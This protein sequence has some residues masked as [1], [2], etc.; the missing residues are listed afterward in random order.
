MFADQGEE[1]YRR[2]VLEKKGGWWQTGRKAK[3][4]AARRIKKIYNVTNFV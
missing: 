4:T 3:I 2:M 1:E